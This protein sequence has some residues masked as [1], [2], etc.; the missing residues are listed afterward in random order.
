MESAGRACFYNSLYHKYAECAKELPR[1][2]TAAA[3]I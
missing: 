3:R 1:Q 2:Y